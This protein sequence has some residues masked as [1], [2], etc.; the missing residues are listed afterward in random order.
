MLNHFDIIISIFALGSYF[1]RRKISAS[2]GP[3]KIKIVLL[4]HRQISNVKVKN[5]CS[6]S[7]FVIVM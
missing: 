2:V 7:I 3:Q 6:F 4:N 1:C 5:I